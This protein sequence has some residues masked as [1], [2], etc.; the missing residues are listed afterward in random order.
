MIK[1]LGWRWAIT[2]VI[3]V[4]GLFYVLPNFIDAT[5]KKWLPNKKLTMGLDIQGGIHLVM[6]VDVQTIIKERTAKMV[7][8]LQ[9]DFKENEIPFQSVDEIDGSDVTIKI[10]FAAEAEAEKI[11]NRLNEGY[12]TVLQVTEAKPTELTVKFYEAYTLQMKKEIVDQAIQVIRNRI[13]EFGV[14]E[15]NISAQGTERILVQLPGIKDSAS[16]KDLINRTAK[17]DFRVVSNDVDFVKLEDMIK[18]A[19]EKGQFKLGVGA[20]GY[21]EYIKRLNTD[22][23][24]QLPKDTRLVFEKLENADS[25]EEGRRPFLVRTDSNLGGSEL[26]DASVRPDEY[27]K[28]EVVFQFSVE[29][30]RLFADLTE[31]ASGGLIAI[32]LDDV[33]K[34]APSVR[35][36]IDSDSARITLGSAR[37]YNATLKEAQFIATALRA[38]SLPAALTQLE[39]RTVGPSMGADAIQKG[40]TATLIACLIVFAFMLVWYRGLGLVADITLAMNLLLTLAGLS[41]LNATLTLPGVAG[42]ALTIGMAVD[43]N[44]I[45]FERIKEEFA[46]TNNTLVAVRN[47]F[48]TAFSA[49]FD[50]NITT[51]L[52]CIILMYYGT[53]PIRGF[54][55]SL[56]IGLVISLFTSVFVA[57]TLLETAAAKWNW[58]LHYKKA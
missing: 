46:R 28:P 23:K 25:L 37:D 30:R 41:A 1:S 32:V 12:G 18:S 6:G 16:A 26:E 34:S 33:V 20:L 2:A 17:L 54:A 50:S 19:E 53:G 21:Q 47:G 58:K 40:E 13:D 10:A 56:T 27:G 29:G 7:K 43:A 42:L 57:R 14:S 11:K 15:P 39:E 52:T 3:T 51:I 8:N 4:F 5:D 24:D 45:I 35:E 48:E 22:L 31:K 36:K 55:V 38:G 9:A 44:I 49:I